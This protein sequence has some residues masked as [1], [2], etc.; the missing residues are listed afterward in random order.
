MV[1][2]TAPG[3]ISEVLEM[4][5]ASVAL[6]LIPLSI[7]S[8]A[9][10]RELAVGT[11]LDDQD[12]RSYCLRAALLFVTI[13]AVSAM[14]SF[15]SQT[16]NGGSPHGAMPSPGL[17]MR[18]RYITGFSIV[19]AVIL[20]LLAKGKGRLLVLGAAISIV[21]VLYVLTHFEMD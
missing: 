12:W 9:W 21:F 3:N 13:T 14:C 6:F 4:Y 1:S 2:S 15:L 10:R 5:I 20:G 19:S 7:I 11:K 16:F 18:L 17:W 8:I